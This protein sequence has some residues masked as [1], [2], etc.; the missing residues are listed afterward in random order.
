MAKNEEN[1]NT[2]QSKES[3]DKPIQDLGSSYHTL[4]EDLENVEKRKNK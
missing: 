4:S 1:Q 3:T 2:D